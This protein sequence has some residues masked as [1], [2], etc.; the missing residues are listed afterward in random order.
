MGKKFILMADDDMD[1]TEMFCEALVAINADVICHCAEDGQE[2]INILNELEELPEIIF[3]DINM[4]IMNGWECL[5]FLKNEKRYHDIPVIMISTSSHQD[6]MNK[7]MNMGAEC[8]FVKPN[9]F[10]DLKDVL[11]S[12]VSNLGNTKDA[13]LNLQQGKSKHIFTC[14]DL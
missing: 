9:S 13:I 14:A 2:A 3:L 1:D 4:P 10:S 5:R 8:Y 12:F 7:A 11:L 6:D